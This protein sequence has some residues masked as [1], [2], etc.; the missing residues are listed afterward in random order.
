MQKTEITSIDDR[1]RTAVGEL[2][3]VVA[4]LR[5]GAR[6]MRALALAATEQTDGVGLIPSDLVEDALL[7]TTD[8]VLDLAETLDDRYRELWEAAM[9]HPTHEGNVP[10]SA[11]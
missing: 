9:G 8:K 10:A 5:Q 3:D 1:V 4:D 2:E 7:F 6:T 11:G